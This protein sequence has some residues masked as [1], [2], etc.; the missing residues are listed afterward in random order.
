MFVIY[1]PFMIGALKSVDLYF[2]KGKKIPL[3]IYTILLILTSYYFSVPGIITIGIY[4][5]YKIFKKTN[6]NRFLQKLKKM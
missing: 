2:E 4:T 6:K 3:I 5:I 1:M